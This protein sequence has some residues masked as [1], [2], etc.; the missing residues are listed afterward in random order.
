[1]TDPIRPDTPHTSRKPRLL[2]A[3]EFSAGKTRLITGLLGEA[4][5]PSNV[6][7]T[8]LP[9]IWLIGGDGLRM[10]VQPDG[11][12]RPVT[13]VTDFDLDDTRYGVMAHGAAILDHFDIIDTPGNSDP[14]IPPETWQ[15]MLDYADAVI[16]CTNATQAWRQSEKSVWDE[17]PE[18]LRKNATLIVTHADRLPDQRA[19]DRVMRR[20]GREAGRY[21][22][23]MFAASLINDADILRIADHLKTVAQGLATRPGADN[24]LMDDAARTARPAAP[25]TSTEAQTTP[26]PPPPAPAAGPVRRLWSRLGGDSDDPAE[27]RDRVERLI[28]ILDSSREDRRRAFDAATR[29]KL[30]PVASEPTCRTDTVSQDLSARAT[31]RK[32]Q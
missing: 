12:T 19:T 29:P 10:A 21:F 22:D 9:P 24:P 13:E 2:V 7:S 6:T 11:T 1:M 27:L 3:G 32:V 23:H 4:L 5:L 17:M 25:A 16:W 30:A 15:V 28:A 26:D 8:A 20:L 31:H 18:A 14:N